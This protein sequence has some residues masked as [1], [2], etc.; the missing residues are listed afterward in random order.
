MLHTMEWKS[1]VRVPCLAS[2]KN[3]NNCSSLLFITLSQAKNTIKVF[4]YNKNI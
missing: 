4:T 2:D 3:K 1:I